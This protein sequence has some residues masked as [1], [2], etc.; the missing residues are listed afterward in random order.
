[1]PDAPIEEVLKAQTTT[2]DVVTR[3]TELARCSEEISRAEYDCALRAENP[4]L[5]EQCLL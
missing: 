2:R 1:M 4:D 3:S 5:F